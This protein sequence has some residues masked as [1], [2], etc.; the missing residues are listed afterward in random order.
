MSVLIDGDKL[1]ALLREK[2]IQHRS[3]ASDI[4][5]KPGWLSRIINQGRPASDECF[6]KMLQILGVPSAVLKRGG[7]TE[8]VSPLEAELLEMFRSLSEV[9]QARAAA[10]I[11]GLHSATRDDG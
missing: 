8:A 6:A 9:N 7:V 2:G 1:R 10:Y 3:F 11:Y 4:G 5:I